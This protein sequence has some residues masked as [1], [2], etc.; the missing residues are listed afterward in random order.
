MKIAIVVPGRFH[1]FDQARAL[2]ERGHE[3]RIFTTYPSWSAR[4][5]GLEPRFLRSFWPLSILDRVNARTGLGPKMEAFLQTSFGKWAA[6]EVSRES[7]DIVHEFSGVGEEVIRAT[8]GQTRHLLLRGSAHIRTQAEILLQ[9]VERT[10]V[11]V[12]QPSPWIIE[13]EEREYA[14]ADYV[15][16]ISR[17]CYDSFLRQGVP[18]KK[19]LLLPLGVDTRAFRVSEEMLERRCQRILSGAPLTVLTTGQVSFRKGLYDFAKIAAACD[20]RMRFRWVGAVLEEA[21]ETVSKLPACVEML[22]HQPQMSLPRSYAEADL[23]LLPTIEDG[24]ALVLAQASANS[25]PILTTT[26]CSGPDFLHEGQSGWVLPIRNPEAFID[27]L[28]WCDAHREALAGMVRDIGRK[29]Q[30]RDW[31]D[32]AADF[33]SLC[34]APV[35][36]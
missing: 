1:A 13:R 9:E 31:S 36:A 28:F 15:V 12:A 19:L 3:I 7:W 35:Q 30:P 8:R 26:N 16:V 11:A 20:G 21:R 33:E 34:A 22:P 24:Y 23:F 2:I 17:F 29:F 4:R 5:F 27:R 6:R 10:G 32:V 18:A 25:L 14:A